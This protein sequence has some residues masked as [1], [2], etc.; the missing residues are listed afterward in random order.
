M[1]YMYILRCANGQYYTGSTKSL[2]RRVAQHQQGRG[3]NFTRKHLPVQLLYYEVY[4]RIDWAFYREKQIQGWSRKKK[5]ALMRGDYG[6]LPQLAECKNESHYLR[7]RFRRV[8]HH[9]TLRLR[10]VCRDA[11]PDETPT[12][13]VHRGAEPDKTPTHSVHRGAEP[14]K[15]PTHSVHR[16]AEPDKTPTHSVHRGAEPDKTRNSLQHTKIPSND[17]I[18]PIRVQRGIRTQE[19]AIAVI[20]LEELL[21]QL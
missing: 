3:A 15:T 4:H 12:H 1:G 16:D 14:D 20:S 8:P 21:E 11:E 17:D 18:R 2:Y 13:S 19:M 7:Q 6:A 9:G 10:S 5:E